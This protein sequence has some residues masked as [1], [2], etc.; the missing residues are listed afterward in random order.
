MRGEDN[1]ASGLSLKRIRLSLDSLPYHFGI[2]GVLSLSKK[3]NMKDLPFTPLYTMGLFFFFFFFSDLL[4]HPRKR[5][6]YTNNPLTDQ[7]FSYQIIYGLTTGIFTMASEHHWEK[8][9][10]RMKISPYKLGR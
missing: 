8:Y 10:G 3:A 6:N 4:N 7:V 5:N 1:R 9:L 2:D